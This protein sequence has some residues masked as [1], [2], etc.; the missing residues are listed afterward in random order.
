[1]YICGQNYTHLFVGNLTLGGAVGTSNAARCE[2][3]VTACK[4]RQKQKQK[5]SINGMCEIDC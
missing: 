2:N 4:K 3:V 5:K 1:M